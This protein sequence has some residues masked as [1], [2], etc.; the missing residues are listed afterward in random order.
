MTF[1][2]LT[3]KLENILLT[4]VTQIKLYT[5]MSFI[6][7]FING[8]YLILTEKCYCCENV[9]ISLSSKNTF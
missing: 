2:F 5:K 8:R 1:N 3:V 6:F 4:G 7:M 9:N